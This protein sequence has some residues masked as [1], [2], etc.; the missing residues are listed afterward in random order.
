MFNHPIISIERLKTQIDMEKS[1]DLYTTTDFTFFFFHTLLTLLLHLSLPSLVL[2]ESFGDGPRP[3]TARKGKKRRILIPQ[4]FS[5]YV[6]MIWLLRIS[7][8][9]FSMFWE[10][11]PLLMGWH[12]SNPFKRMAETLFFSLYIDGIKTTG[13]PVML[14]LLHGLALIV[15]VLYLS[16]LYFF[17]YP[18]L[19][20][21]VF[22]F[23]RF[24]RNF[25][26]HVHNAFFPYFFQTT[27]SPEDPIVLHCVELVGQVFLYSGNFRYLDTYLGRY[28]W[29]SS[30]LENGTVCVWITGYVIVNASVLDVSCGNITHLQ[31]ETGTFMTALELDRD[32]SCRLIESFHQLPT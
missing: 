22:S 7:F 24:S 20:I 4:L 16:T 26:F 29:E 31:H 30:K 21:F 11:L 6:F 12:D 8:F 27:C 25:L 2:D 13:N 32:A 1:L 18:S 10:K 23:F 28:L 3:S 17:F 15:F 9:P 19:Q 5:T 14:C